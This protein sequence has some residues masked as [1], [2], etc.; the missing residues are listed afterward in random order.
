MKPGC[1]RT[2]SIKAK[3]VPDRIF[4]PCTGHKT[5]GPDVLSDEYGKNPIQNSRTGKKSPASIHLID[6]GPIL[7]KD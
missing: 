3:K 5:P 4:R 1:F 6:S 2:R 7:K